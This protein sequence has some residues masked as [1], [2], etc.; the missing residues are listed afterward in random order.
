MKLALSVLEPHDRVLVLGKTGSGKSNTAK[1]LVEKNT[2]FWRVVVVDPHDEYSKK[3]VKRSETKLGTLRQRCTVDE[4]GAD[5]ARWLDGDDVELSVVLTGETAELR[6]AEAERV[7]ELVGDTGNILLVLDEVGDYGEYIVKAI[8][9]AA[10]QWR[11]RRIPMILVAQCATQVH[12]VT[13][14]QASQ[15][16]SG[17]QDDPEDIKA[18]HNRTYRQMPDFA[19]R[20][21]QLPR[22]QLLHWRDEF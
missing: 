17:L 1:D 21:A 18:I 9:E 2:P 13:R 10:T 14:R 15:I 8:N 16:I 22:G 11:K 19:E 20:V 6:A 12:K 5:P 7:L 4:L 3:G